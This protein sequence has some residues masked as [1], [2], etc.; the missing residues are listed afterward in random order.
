[1]KLNNFSLALLL[2]VGAFLFNSTS[3]D[4]LVEEVVKSEGLMIRW[5]K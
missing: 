1:M 3:I 2:I 5:S 4:E